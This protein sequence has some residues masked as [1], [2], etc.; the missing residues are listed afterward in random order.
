MVVSALLRQSLHFERPLLNLVKSAQCFLFQKNE[1]HSNQTAFGVQKFINAGID[2]TKYTMKPIPLSKSGGRG[3][4]GRIQTH[5]I[6]GGHRKNYRMVDFKKDGPRE[7]PP[8]V[9]VVKCVRYDPCRTADIAV[10]ATGVNKRYILASQN[11]KAGDLIKTSRHIPRMAVKA[12]EGD[13]Y[14][15]GALPIGTLVHNVEIYTDNY[16]KM[17]RAAG[18]C[19]QLVRKVGNQC[20]VRLPSKREICVSKHCMA[21][22]GRVSNVEHN[23]EHIGSAQRSRW[24]GIRPQSGLWHRK[25]GYN[26]RKI[27]PVPPL[28]TYSKSKPAKPA[29]HVF[30]F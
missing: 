17:A 2:V 13:S 1:F 4:D 3:H 21:T 7:G 10:V 27:R 20:V 9:E 29:M 23:K 28:K 24:L 18:T 25:T 22:V 26:G 16:G 5:G 14:P 15:L 12:N 30:S 8:L 19:A 11:M 6:G